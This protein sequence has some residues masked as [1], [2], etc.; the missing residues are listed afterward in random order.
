[1]ILVALISPVA[2]IVVFAAL[3]LLSKR[4]G[5]VSNRPP[6]YRG[7]YVGAAFVALGGLLRVLWGDANAVLIG[8]RALVYD[9]PVFL[10]VGIAV[11]VTWRCWGWLLTE[12][13]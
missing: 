11:V 4:L 10:G 8:D 7:Y 1:M 9:L 5:E 12:R 13:D 3:A 2:L 6:I